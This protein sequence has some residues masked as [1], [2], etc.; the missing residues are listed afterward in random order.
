MDEEL[1][2]KTKKTAHM[3]FRTLKGGTGFELWQKFDKEL[4]WCLRSSPHISRRPVPGSTP[5]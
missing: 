2:E 3:L 5:L 4:V 1:K